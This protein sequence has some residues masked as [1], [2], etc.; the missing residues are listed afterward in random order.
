MI[1]VVLS[2]YQMFIIKSYRPV[3][4]AP[5][6]LAELLFHSLA[7]KIPVEVIE[8]VFKALAALTLV[9]TSLIPP[10]FYRNTLKKILSKKI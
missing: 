5:N 7:I 6:H 1:A 9:I 2:N 4:L 3:W 8:C 10:A